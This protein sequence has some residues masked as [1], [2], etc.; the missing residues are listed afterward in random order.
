MGYRN[1]STRVKLRLNTQVVM[2]NNLT[3]TLLDLSHYM[4]LVYSY[5]HGAYAP[6]PAV[7]LDAGALTRFRLPNT[8]TPCAQLYVNIPA[9][10]MVF[11]LHI[12]V[13]VRNSHLSVIHDFS[14]QFIY[15][16]IL[17]VGRHAFE[18]SLSRL[19]AVSFPK[20]VHLPLVLSE[21]GRTFLDS[22]NTACIASP[23]FLL[24]LANYIC[25]LLAP[26]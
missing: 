7:N 19:K 9:S 12:R 22:R 2:R 6:E 5:K 8:V 20:S 11:I 4:Y 13:H 21:S 25:F 14:G 18:T 24:T 10:V 26:I 23:P 15:V 16:P 3:R 1:L 17:R